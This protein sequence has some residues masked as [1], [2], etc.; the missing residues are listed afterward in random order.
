MIRERVLT[1]DAVSV[2]EQMAQASSEGT[3][4]ALE[5][6]RASGVKLGS[7][8][9][10]TAANAASKRARAQRSDSVVDAIAR[11]ILEDLAYRDLSHRAF[12]DLLNR[13]NLLT[14]WSRPWT[15]AGVKRQ[16]KEAE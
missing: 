10:R 8:S 13:R 6:K 16:R 3:I 12:A 11:V 7:K 15:A 2:G 5:K 4:K 1:L 9:D 14:G